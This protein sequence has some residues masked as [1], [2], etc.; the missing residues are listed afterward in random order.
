MRSLLIFWLGAGLC[1]GCQSYSWKSS[2]PSEMRTVSV[3]VFANESDVPE[4]GSAVARQISREL[5][6]E[7]TFQIVSPDTCAIEVQGIVRSAHSSVN[8]YS[9]RTGSRLRDYHL[10]TVA[11]VSFIDKR[12]GRVWVDGRKY[13]AQTSFTAGDDLLTGARD[14]SGRIAADLARQ[15]VDDLRAEAASASTDTA[16]ERDTTDVSR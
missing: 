15:V 9:R 6:R 3:G 14:A 13:S 12:A 7:G 2:V 11:E 1:V 16:A 4:L 8:G 10:T 5:Q